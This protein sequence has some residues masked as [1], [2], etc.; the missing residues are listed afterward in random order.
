MQ[1]APAKAV[2]HIT[3]KR[4]FICCYKWSHHLFFLYVYG[5]LLSAPRQIESSTAI[6]FAVYFRW[7]LNTYVFV[8]GSAA[9][10]RARL[11]AASAM[12]VYLACVLYKYIKFYMFLVEKLAR[13]LL[14]LLQQ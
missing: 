5:A 8:L 13:R 7:Q 14:F 11:H 4:L 1:I 3:L 10:L 12:F 6:N 2:Y 9:A